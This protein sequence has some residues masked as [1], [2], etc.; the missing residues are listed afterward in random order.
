MLYRSA[1]V[2]GLATAYRYSKR[3]VEL[4]CCDASFESSET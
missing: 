2:I 3:Q 1:L 4:I